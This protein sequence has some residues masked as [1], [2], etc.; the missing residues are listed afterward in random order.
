MERGAVTE[1]TGLS[2]RDLDGLAV[3]DR[4]FDLPEL[5]QD[6]LRS[7]LSRCHFVPLS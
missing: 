1:R 7:V 4:H 6:L 2:D 3:R 5:Q